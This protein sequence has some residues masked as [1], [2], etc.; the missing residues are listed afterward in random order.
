M[1]HDD[2]IW[3]R[4]LVAENLPYEAPTASCQQLS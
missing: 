4:Y 2:T 1:R 3:C